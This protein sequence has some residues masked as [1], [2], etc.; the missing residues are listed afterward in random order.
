MSAFLNRFLPVIIDLALPIGPLLNSSLVRI[1]RPETAAPVSQS[2]LGQSCAMRDIA[3][4]DEHSRSGLGVEKILEDSNLGAAVRAVLLM[5]FASA[6]LPTFANYQAPSLMGCLP[7]DGGA[8]YRSSN[9]S[10]D[11]QPPPTLKQDVKVSACSFP[12]GEKSARAHNFGLIECTVNN[13]S[14]EP[15]ESVK[16]GI[17]YFIEGEQTALIEAGFDGARTFSTANI[18]GNLSPNETRTLTF[19]GPK[20]PSETGSARIVPTIEVLGA[21]TPGSFAFR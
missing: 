17:R 11:Y 6:A 21:R 10:L 7:S 5:L 20:L 15:I 13:G 19:V 8:S 4:I 2:P 12:G 14:K 1:A 3:V 16:Y 9:C 18:S